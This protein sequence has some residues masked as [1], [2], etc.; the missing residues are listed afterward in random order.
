[1]RNPA[2]SV[3][4]WMCMVALCILSTQCS[5]AGGDAPTREIVEKLLK[6]QWDKPKPPKSDGKVVLTLNGIKFGT[7]YKA[8]L[9]EVQVHRFPEG[10]MVTPAKIDYTVRTYY[11]SRTAASHWDRI[12]ALVFKDKFGE[13]TV[14][15]SGGSTHFT[16]T[17]EPA[18]K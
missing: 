7:A 14:Y 10:A 3:T 8:T 13:W 6:S 12:E 2:R 17:D 18:E 4:V 11:N 9:Q 5:Q 1:M 15:E 16:N